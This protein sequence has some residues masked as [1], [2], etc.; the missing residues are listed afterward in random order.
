MGGA[1]LSHTAENS[2]RESSGSAALQRRVNET[3]RNRP[4]GP[5]Y[6]PVSTM[7]S[8]RRGVRNEVPQ[9][10]KPALIDSAERGPEG[11]HYP[12]GAQRF[13]RFSRDAN[14]PPGTDRKS[15]RLNSSH[16]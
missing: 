9:R 12:S 2:S 6:M 1:C 11:P 4:L 15:T 16:L 7:P 13:F 5:R 8:V 10:L 14:T 3:M